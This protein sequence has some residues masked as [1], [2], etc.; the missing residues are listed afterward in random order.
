[1]QPRFQ[2]CT[3]KIKCKFEILI[4]FIMIL[5]LDIIKEEIN[6]QDEQKSFDKI[7]YPLLQDDNKF[8][9]EQFIPDEIIEEDD[10]NRE[11][12]KENMQQMASM[13]F[14]GLGGFYTD[15]AIDF[16]E[17]KPQNY[18]YR[19]LT[20][21]SNF[22]QIFRTSEVEL[23]NLENQNRNLFENFSTFAACSILIYQTINNA[24]IPAWIMTIPLDKYLRITWRFWIQ[25]MFLIPVMMYEQRTGSQQVKSQYEFRY[26]FQWENM[27]Q[28]YYASIS[29][30]IASTIFLFCFDYNYIATIFILGSQTN[31]WLSA[32]RVQSQNHI[33]EKRGQ[34]FSFFGYKLKQQ[35]F[36]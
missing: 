10:K 15:Q 12:N 1:M 4:E 23:D 19:R 14:I 28:L 25:S 6:E 22:T 35:D 16:Q 5:N 31:F 20:I 7:Q 30:T 8:E 9:N 18:Q 2:N 17:T 33:L 3:V 34:I 36:C 21:Y 26:I 13:V 32:V 11:S 27:R 29:P 24:M